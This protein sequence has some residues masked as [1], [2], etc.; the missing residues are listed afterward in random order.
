MRIKYA[1]LNK[2]GISLVEI[3][4]TVL[5]SSIL[6]AGLYVALN[7][8]KKSWEENTIRIELQQELRKA[9]EWMKRELLEAGPTSITNVSANG[10]P[11]TYINFKMPSGI[12]D[13]SIIWDSNPIQFALGG[14]TG[15]DLIRAYNG[16]KIIAKNINS[17][18][19]TRQ[20]TTPD[21]LEVSINA[22]ETTTNGRTLDLQTEFQIKLRN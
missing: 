5:I 7:V 20:S 4:V 18:E 19:F 16:T 9:T 10:S 1:P 8:A 2:S 12:T 11:E 14:T 6:I 22:Q 3:M 17:I 21:I 15:T 13:G